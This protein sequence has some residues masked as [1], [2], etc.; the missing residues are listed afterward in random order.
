MKNRRAVEFL[1]IWETIDNTA[2][3]CGEFTTIKCRAK[4]RA[5]LFGVGNK[6]T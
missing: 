1:G 3:N 5:S 4:N 6:W 2:F